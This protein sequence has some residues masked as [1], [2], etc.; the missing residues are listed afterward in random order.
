MRNGL[1]RAQG[2]NDIDARGSHRGPRG[3]DHGGRQQYARR[4]DHDPRPRH[5]RSL[6]IT[7]GQA[8][9]REARTLIR[10]RFPRP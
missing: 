1:V 3:G 4:P 8:L 6:E 10:C 5:P 7:A 2:L 9:Q